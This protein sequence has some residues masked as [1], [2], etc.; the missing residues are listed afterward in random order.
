ML[1]GG[2]PAKRQPER[3]CIS[4]GKAAFEQPVRQSGYQRLPVGKNMHGSS[5]GGLSGHHGVFHTHGAGAAFAG[6]GA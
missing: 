5:G 4:L 2:T 1:G 3:C 6:A